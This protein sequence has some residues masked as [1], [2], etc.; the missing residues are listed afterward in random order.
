MGFEIDGH[1]FAVWAGLSRKRKKNSSAGFLKGLLKALSIHQCFTNEVPPTVTG[2]ATSPPSVTPVPPERGNY[3]VT[4][5]NGTV[6]LLARMGLQLNISYLSTSHGKTVQELMNLHPNI[7]KTSGSC[8]PDN[9]KLV[10]T[11]NNITLTLIFTLNSTLNKYH[12]SGVEL[13]AALPNMSK[14]LFVSNTS[15]N[16]W[17]GTLGHSYMCRKE[18]TLNVTQDFSLNTFELQVQPFG[19]NGDFGSAEECA[20]DEDDMLIPIIVGAAL[21]VL[22]LIVI[23][24]YLIGRNR[25]HAGYQTI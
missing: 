6:C 16:Y 1:T 7:T 3:N 18:Q 24:A 14:T 23:L 9:A 17:V 19:V 13:L 20:L 8:E 5:A 4:N 25:S 21:A 12:L 15:L 22:V 11:E 10:L 2:S